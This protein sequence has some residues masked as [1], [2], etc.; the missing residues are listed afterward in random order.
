MFV[1]AIVMIVFARLIA[2]SMAFGV[3][4]L[5]AVVGAFLRPLGVSPVIGM[6]PA[7]VLF[8]VTP[9]GV[10]LCHRPQ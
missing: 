6:S 8:C 7:A 3:R 5:I 10:H 4:D 2:D 1:R 9:V